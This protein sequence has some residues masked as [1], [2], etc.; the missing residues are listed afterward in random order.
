MEKSVFLSLKLCDLLPSVSQKIPMPQI[1]RSLEDLPYLEEK[2]RNMLPV[3]FPI[4]STFAVG[5]C[6]WDEADLCLNT[7]VFV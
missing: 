1:A 3:L 7:T 4:S 5:Q 6:R 2:Y